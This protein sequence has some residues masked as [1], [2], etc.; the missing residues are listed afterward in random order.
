MPLPIEDYAL[1]GDT[2]AAA[3][4]G[5]NGSIDWLCLPRFDSPACF[6]ALLGTVD[7]GRW[8]LAPKGAERAA[9]RRYLDR[10]LVLETEWEVPDGRVRVTDFMPPRSELPD[11]VRIVEGVSGE[12]EMEMELV[13]RFDYG[14]LVPWV[15]QVGGDVCGVAGP[16][17]VCLR[18][19]VPTHGENLRTVARFTARPGETV[20][21]VLGWHPSHTPPREPPHAGG[22]LESTLDWWRAW[23]GRMRYEG[24]WVAE[25][26]H[27]LMVLKALTY[28]PTGGMVAAPTTSLPEQ[29]GGVRNWDYRY[30]WVRDAAFAL[31]ALHIGGYTDETRAWRNWLLRASAGDPAAL[32]VL[33]GPAGESRL[34]ELELDW[35]CGYE[36]SRP[37]RVGNAASEQYQLDIYGEVLDA[38]HLARVFGIESS[39]ESWSMQRLLVDFVEAHWREPD[40]GIWE[41]RGPRRQFT[42]SKV[43][44][45]VAVDR[46]VRAVEKFGLEG[47]VERW[48]QLR[49]EIHD[50]VCQNGY[51]GERNTFTQYYGSKEL[52]ASLLMIPLVHFLPATDRRMRGTVEAIKR[53]LMEDGFVLR[54]RSESTVDGLPP[55]EGAFLACTFWL[56]DNLALMGDL[57]EATAIFKRLLSLRNDVGL[58]AEEY[59]S[60][61]GRLVGNFPQAFTHVGLVNSAYNLDR[62]RKARARAM[63]SA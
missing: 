29:I 22:A 57:E 9:R 19:S 23:C 12:V 17:A 15:R 47:P 44:A 42:H 45:W 56:V 14:R 33:Y 41:V 34:P 58:L 28:A 20:S 51:D 52:D 32:Q 54:Y 40:E 21:F 6:A 26:Q 48:R 30:C 43:M 61:L 13:L 8:L 5:M 27:S 7:N 25:V 63:R 49:E 18:S 24:E 36:D 39:R 10:A 11:L 59:D 16:E 53:E 62:A 2:Q 38:L 31:W 55:G 3:L 1:I 4:V 46:A 37:V 60:R 35:L 50:D